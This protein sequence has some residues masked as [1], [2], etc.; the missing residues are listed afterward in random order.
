MMWTDLFGAEHFTQRLPRR[1]LE[2][3][4]SYSER[5]LGLRNGTTTFA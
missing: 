5:G 1:C 2:E 3:V 4:A